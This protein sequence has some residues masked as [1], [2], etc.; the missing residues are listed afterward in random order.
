MKVITSVAGATAQDCVSRRAVHQ[1]HDVHNFYCSGC[2]DS[3]MFRLS[4][5]AIFR[6]R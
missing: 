4:K 3:Y 2:D 5:A 1:R 6:Q